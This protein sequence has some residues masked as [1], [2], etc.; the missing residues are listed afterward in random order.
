M[1]E[2]Q[3]RSHLW[4]LVST[5]FFGE[6]ENIRFTQSKDHKVQYVFFFELPENGRAI[7]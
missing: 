2:D 7:E 6:A 1:D 4:N 3:R 5:M